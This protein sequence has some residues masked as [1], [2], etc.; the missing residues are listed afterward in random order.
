MG[1]RVSLVSLIVEGIGLALKRVW[2]LTRAGLLVIA[3]LGMLAVN[4]ATLTYEP[5]ARALSAFVELILPEGSVVGR[6][7]RGLSR[8]AAEVSEANRRVDDLERRGSRLESELREERRNGQSARARVAELEREKARLGTDL[9][10]E[11]AHARRLQSELDLEVAETRR[12]EADRNLTRTRVDQTSARIVHRNRSRA[13]RT[14]AMLASEAFPYVGIP[15]LLAETG[16]ELADL[17]A[18]TRDMIELR[19]HLGIDGPAEEDSDYV[20]GMRVPSIDELWDRIRGGSTIE[21]CTKLL[22]R[23]VDSRYCELPQ[24]PPLTPV[25]TPRPP[26]DPPQGVPPQ[27]PPTPDPPEPPR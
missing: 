25:P 16:W 27:R 10:R 4:F 5:F 26:P 23:S 3:V 19:Q 14:V 15:L 2:R 11:R 21:D 24:A 18:S 12:L 6:K 20:C 9:E 22:P 13:Q 1:N 7:S 8:A 17:C